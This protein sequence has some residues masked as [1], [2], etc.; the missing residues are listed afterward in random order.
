[1][2]DIK[3]YDEK[4]RDLQGHLTFLGNLIKNLE[5]K[6]NVVDHLKKIK[7]LYELVESTKTRRHPIDMLIKV[8]KAIN[9]VKARS[10]TKSNDPSHHN[11]SVKKEGKYSEVSDTPDSPT[12]SPTRHYGRTTP[13]EIPTERSDDRDQKFHK[14]KDSR[15][16]DNRRHRSDHHRSDRSDKYN[17]SRYSG[18]DR[19]RSRFDQHE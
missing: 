19:N 10:E 1:K 6:P 3:V 9:V 11:V 5:A 7:K 18:S 12:P 17:F 4:V 2:M 13:I 16:D 14:E 8:E 15:Y